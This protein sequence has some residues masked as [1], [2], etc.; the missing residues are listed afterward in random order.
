MDV[1]GLREV[2][3]LMLKE[4]PAAVARRVTLNAIRSSAKPMK[5]AAQ[6]KVVKKSHALMQSINTKT[7][8]QRMSKTFASMTLS[9]ISG[10]AAAWAR[11]MVYYRRPVDIDKVGRIRHG[12]L[13]EFGFRHVSGKFVKARPFLRPAFDQEYQTFVSIFKKR[14]RTRVINAVKKQRAIRGVK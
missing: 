10:N 8:P 6:V 2:E 1:F 7:T 4:L 9:P 13:V 11:Y 3:Q 5:E 14:L 12:H